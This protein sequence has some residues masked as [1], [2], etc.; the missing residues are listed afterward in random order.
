MS[1]TQAT[2]QPA[3]APKS[4]PTI[5]DLVRAVQLLALRIE[6]R[7]ASNMAIASVLTL[8]PITAQL[9]P[10]DAGRIAAAMTK[11]QP[12]DLTRKMAVASAI[13][14]VQGAKALHRRPADA[15]GAANLQAQAAAQPETPAVA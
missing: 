4:E 13:S 14:I 9:N 2:D 12:N 15:A 1:G 8:L 11:K 6:Q 5:A 10:S 3:A 7:T